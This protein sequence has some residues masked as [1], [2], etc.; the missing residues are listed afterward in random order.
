M[1]FESLKVAESS[2]STSNLPRLPSRLNWTRPIFS[3]IKFL[4][5]LTFPPNLHLLTFPLFISLF[6]LFF[7]SSP[8]SLRVFF[9][10]KFPW[11]VF[12]FFCSVFSYSLLTSWDHFFLCIGSFFFFA[13]SPCFL[14]FFLSFSFHH[15]FSRKFFVS[16]FSLSLFFVVVINI[17]FNSIKCIFFDFCHRYCELLNER[18]K[19]KKLEKI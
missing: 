10:F 13:S 19:L 2:Q 3:M 11:L 6:S 12:V 18:E 17:I 1:C 4:I 8:L 5:T 9:L 14:F 7:N 16:F 15:Q